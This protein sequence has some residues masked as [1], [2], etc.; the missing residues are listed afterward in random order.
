M[1]DVYNSTGDAIKAIGSS[2]I[3]SFGIYC[4]GYQG[5]QAES[6]SGGKSTL[7]DYVNGATFIGRLDYPSVG[8]LCKGY[9]GLQ[10]QSHQ[11]GNDYGVA[12]LGTPLDGAAFDSPAAAGGNGLSLSGYYGLQAVG[13]TESGIYARGALNQS[14][15]TFAGFG[16]GNGM[17]LYA[18]DSGAALKTYSYAGK[19]IDAKEIGS[20]FTIDGVTGAGI[21]DVLKK[22]VDDNGGATYDAALHS[23]ASVKSQI[24]AALGLN[25][26]YTMDEL[27]AEALPE[28]PT[29]AEAKMLT[30]MLQKNIVETTS[31]LQ[32]LYDHAGTSKILQWALSDDGTTFTRD[33]AVSG[34]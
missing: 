6:Y 3:E 20:V 15:V 33:N 23:L 24:G 7:G 17:L 31:N 13:I 18:G 8:L 26:T 22:V 30:S 14:G 10:A 9:T 34:A 12:S 27:A 28:K 19:G 5:L 32:S 11:L 29:M 21:L 2:N 16:T 4:K 25:A 1:L